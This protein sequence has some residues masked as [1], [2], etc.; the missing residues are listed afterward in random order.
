M[1]I[2]RASSYQ[3]GKQGPAIPAPMGIYLQRE[4]RSRIGES[5]SISPGAA[6]GS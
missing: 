2:K 6:S 4:I 1:G 5:G 3:R